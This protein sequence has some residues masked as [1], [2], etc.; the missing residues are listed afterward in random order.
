MNPIDM[1]M[2]RFNLQNQKISDMERFSGLNGQKDIKEESL[3]QAASEFEAVFV[4]QLF[5]VMDKTVQKS[6]LFHGGQA[7]D[8]FKSMLND[9]MAKNIASSPTTSF[10]LAEQIYQQMKDRI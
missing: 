4:K 2:A 7:E 5:E 10:G 8:I 1:N 9:E 3:K 6:E